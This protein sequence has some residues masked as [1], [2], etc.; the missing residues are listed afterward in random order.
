MD[1]TGERYI[2]GMLG[3]IE[4]EHLH[5]YAL[6]RMVV[7]DLDVL[8]VASGEGYG[9]FLL[10]G[11]ARSVIGI[12]NSEEAIE[13]ARMRYNGR[14]SNIRFRLG[15][16]SSLPVETGSVDAVISFETIEHHG[17][18]EQ[19]MLEIG[20]VLRPG[21][22]LL[23]STPDRRIYSEAAQYCNP[24][25][26]KELDLIEFSALLRRHF[27]FVTIYGQTTAP[28]SLLR[29][30]VTASATPLTLM[31][32][33]GSDVLDLNRTS[34]AATYLIAVC[35]NEVSRQPALSASVF[36]R[37]DYTNGRGL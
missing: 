5:R 11:A 25:H 37:P 8:D 7:K 14:A 18:H 20:R 23:I 30:L 3:D 34:F 26:V 22:F 29:P 17:E 13:F 35:C 21:G 15:T 28:V 32:G 2:P 31:A 27:E 24:Y 16:C 4:V 12:D 36:Y 1:A 10:A 33:A 6:G 19:M 9:T